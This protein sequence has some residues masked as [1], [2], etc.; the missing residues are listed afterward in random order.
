MIDP[1]ME[2]KYRPGADVST[3]PYSKLARA[4][5]HAARLQSEVRLWIAEQPIG[6]RAELSDDR[7]LWTLKVVVNERPPIQR[8]STIIGDC[9]HNL[10]SALDSAVWEFA[11]YSGSAPARPHQIQ[12]PIVDKPND[13]IRTAERQLAGVPSEVV[14]RI[15]VMQPFMHPEDDR[16]RHAAVMLQF[17]SNTDKH[18][19][20]IKCGFGAESLNADFGVDFGDPAIADRNTPPDLQIHDFV[21][22][23]GSVLVEYRAKDPILRTIGGFGVALKLVVDTPTGPMDLEQSMNSLVQ[24]VETVL[25][26]MHGGVQ[27]VETPGDESQTEG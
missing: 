25:A 4:I 14:E 18:R 2:P 7:R 8:W 11:C 1:L 17:I 26:V 27:R 12:F 6:T 22:E 9:I 21:L 5:D 23:D 10:R 15:R 19:T 13:W 24:Y 16:A 3:W 20:S